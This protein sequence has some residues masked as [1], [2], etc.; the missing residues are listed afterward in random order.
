MIRRRILEEIE[1]Q[2]TSF[3]STRNLAWQQ[4]FSGD[5]AFKSEKHEQDFLTYLESTRKH[6]ELVD[7]YFPFRNVT[8]SHKVES[9][10]KRVGL[11]LPKVLL[12]DV[13]GEVQESVP[14][15][16]SCAK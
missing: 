11:D 15:A 3:G 12:G 2:F 5:N 8:E 16:Q 4:C 7:L 1:K 6:K 9:A 14:K 13:N 10:A